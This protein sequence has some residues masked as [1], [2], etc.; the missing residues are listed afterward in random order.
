MLD[1]STRA[2]D[3]FCAETRL[4]ACNAARFKRIVNGVEARRVSPDKIARKILS[5]LEKKNPGF[6]YSINRNP[7]LLLLNALPKRVQFWAIRL[8]LR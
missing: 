2:L 7:L 3:R 4:Y 6:A 5:I 8:V 1:V